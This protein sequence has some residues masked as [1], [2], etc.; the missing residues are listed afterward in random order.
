MPVPK[1]RLV[2]QLRTL[3]DLSATVNSTL[4]A[5]EIQQR[6]VES[7]ATIVDAERSSL[8]IL[9]PDTSDLCFEVSQGA[10]GATVREVRLR[11]GQGVAGWVVDNQQG[12]VIDDVHADPRY[13]D[14]KNENSP[15]STRNMV[16]VP[17]LSRGEVI[18][19]LQAMNKRGGGRFD[20]N[21]CE[22]MQSLA[23]HVAVAIENA[24]LY[25][26]I[27]EAF[28]QTAEV[29]AHTI[30][31]A[32]PY[33]G[34]HI[35]RVM[36]FSVAIGLRL[37]LSA[38]ERENVRLAAVL[39]DVGKI[40]VPDHVLS[41]QDELRDYE[42]ELIKRHSSTG[43]D[44]L[45]KAMHLHPVM[46]AVRGH[47]ER[48]DGQGY[49]DGLSGTDIPLAARIIAVADSFDAMTSERPYREPLS[50]DAAIEEVRAC[51]GSQFDPEVAHAFIQI[52]ESDTLHRRQN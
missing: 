19:A 40:A 50:W 29:L 20:D 9:D 8:L 51:S 14:A 15:V 23:H 5:S 38:A 6:A 28:Y 46:G 33:T 42:L 18:G 12:V 4:D 31:Q 21:D 25:Q 3:M 48:W 1:E 11:A 49:P 13:I 44:I 37:G 24:N 47:H 41:K 39:H 35:K 16:C 30:E 45:G 43:S 27:K 36:E 2:V 52:L 22:L 26:G 7:A 17:V 32:D 34:Q 10:T